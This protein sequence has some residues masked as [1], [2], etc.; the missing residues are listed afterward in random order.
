MVKL[1]VLPIV[2][3]LALVVAVEGGICAKNVVVASPTF[4]LP[5]YVS[6]MIVPLPLMDPDTTCAASDV[7][8]VHE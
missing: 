5:E 8:T 6:Q 1:R 2:V 4:V 3:S 7:G